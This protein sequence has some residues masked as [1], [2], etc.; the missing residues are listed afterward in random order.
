MKI[1]AS[2]SRYSWRREIGLA[3]LDTCRGWKFGLMSLR[4]I[5]SPNFQ[6]WRV[7]LRLW[8]ILENATASWRSQISRFNNDESCDI[9]LMFK[10]SKSVKLPI[11]LREDNYNFLP[12]RSSL[13]FVGI[14]LIRNIL[15][16]WVIV[17]TFNYNFTVRKC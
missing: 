2:Y 17:S 4:R 7:L 5:V 16:S 15:N 1:W 12:A 13:C 8:A 11:K 10:I 6:P 14:L 3:T 9:F